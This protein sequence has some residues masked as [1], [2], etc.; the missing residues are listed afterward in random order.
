[1]KRL[2]ALAMVAAIAGC[3]TPRLQD[4][5]QVGDLAGT[6]VDGTLQVLT[7]QHRYCTE[8]DPVARAILLR[9]IRTAVPGYPADGLCTDLLDALG[10]NNAIPD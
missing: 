4:G 7:L 3:S 1:M 9:V 10:D 6:A 2:I 5:Y 8:S